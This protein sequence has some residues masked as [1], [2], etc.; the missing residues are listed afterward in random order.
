M[1]HI[2]IDDIELYYEVH[3]KG[4][5]LLVIAGLASDSQSW[6]PLTPLLSDAFQV[7]AP[8]NRTTGRTTPRDAPTSVERMAADA[9]AAFDALGVEKAHVLGHSMGGVV[10]M[11]LAASYPERVDKLVVCGT[12]L[13]R[14]A[15]TLSLAR[16]MIALKRAGAPEDLWYRNFFYWLF[17]PSFFDVPEN[18]DAAVAISMDYPYAQDIDGME[19]QI[20]AVEA[21]QPADLAARISA[22]VLAVHGGRDLMIAPQDARASLSAISGLDFE[23]MPHCAHSLHWDDPQGFAGIV[24]RYLTDG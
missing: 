2:A 21:F 13:A 8:D 20:D 22:P 17:A 24:K 19:R 12:S 7:I 3:G 14:N 18:V 10:A 6:A 15:R 11:A 9:V 4:A 16:T 23:T 1:P 5:P